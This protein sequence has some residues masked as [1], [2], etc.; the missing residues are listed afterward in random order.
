MFRG[1]DWNWG[2][3]A[4][5]L[6]GSPLRASRDWS[7]A[8]ALDRL[9]ALGVWATEEL[10]L[11]G[12]ELNVLGR[13]GHCV[14]AIRGFGGDTGDLPIGT[15]PKGSFR[16]VHSQRGEICPMEFNCGTILGDVRLDAAASRR[17]SARCLDRLYAANASPKD[18]Q[19]PMNRTNHPAWN[20]C[21]MSL[22]AATIEAIAI[23]WGVPLDDVLNCSPIKGGWRNEPRRMILTPDL[24]RN[25]RLL[26]P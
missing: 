22:W 24:I 1:W 26:S 23:A 4:G 21:W 8:L 11:L 2:Y 15:I 14:L 12:S 18:T 9:D 7:Q 6:I 3:I 25:P 5:L 10:V 17:E 20:L 16:S 19:D 13:I